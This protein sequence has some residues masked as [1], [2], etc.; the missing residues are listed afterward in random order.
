MKSYLSVIIDTIF[1]LLVVFVLSLI[2]LTYFLPSTPALILS[3]LLGSIFSLLILK[4]LLD[5][6]KGA[7]NSI[8]EK[9][10][11]E[12]LITELNFL[13]QKSVL[14]HFYTLF[15]NQG[16]KIYLNGKHICFKDNPAVLKFCFGFAK[17]E[18]TDLV[19]FFNSLLDSQT[20]YLLSSEFSK[21]I[22]QFNKCFGGKIVLV[23]GDEVYK[24]LKEHGALLPKRFS[25]IKKKPSSVALLNLFKKKKAKNFL[26]LGLIFLFMS[27]FVP[28]KLYYVV[29]GCL[30]L[31]YA[32][33]LRLF[34]R[35]EKID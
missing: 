25:S 20:G 23:S 12:S 10:E 7:L 17:V 30:F 29:C 31:S 9:R 27:Y 14:S 16:Y 34:G 22:I 15:E 8:R 5:K 32:L 24:Y 6:R 4:R 28:I 19:N 33:F 3:S 2:L 26:F 1:S 13:P 11:R 18:K 35:A 21:E